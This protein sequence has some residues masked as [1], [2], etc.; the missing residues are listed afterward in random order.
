ME[1]SGDRCGKAFEVSKTL[2]LF[3]LDVSKA[4]FAPFISPAAIMV[5]VACGLVTFMFPP[6]K[7]SPFAFVPPMSGVAGAFAMKGLAASL[8]TFDIAKGS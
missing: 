1:P 5:S 2:A 6:F 7:L 8:F 4:A 3:M